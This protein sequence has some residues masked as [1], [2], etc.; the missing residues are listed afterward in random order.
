MTN[1]PGRYVLILD[2]GTS[3]VTNSAVVQERQAYTSHK[4]YTKDGYRCCILNLDT[5]EVV[6]RSEGGDDG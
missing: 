2:N 1:E 6:E 3:I 5:M 4:A